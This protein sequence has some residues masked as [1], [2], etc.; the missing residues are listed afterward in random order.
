MKRILKILFGIAMVIASIALS[1]GIYMVC[2]DPKT[3]GKE[4]GDMMVGIFFCIIAIP[5][6]F[7]K[8]IQFV[9]DKDAS[10]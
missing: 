7:F 10:L 6:F 1:F 8:G 5:V 9:I 4:M 2:S 3:T